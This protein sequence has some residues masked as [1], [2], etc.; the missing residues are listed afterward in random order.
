MDRVNLIPLSSGPCHF[1][2]VLH[3][4]SGIAM[5]DST[6][7]IQHNNWNFIAMMQYNPR[8]CYQY[9]PV[10]PLS[11]VSLKLPVQDRKGSRLPIHGPPNSGSDVELSRRLYPPQTKTA[12][13]FVK[14]RLIWYH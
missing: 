10:R 7:I 14:E 3:P 13:T 9:G 2:S 11:S 1:K 6:T 5:F 12:G 8:L 4:I